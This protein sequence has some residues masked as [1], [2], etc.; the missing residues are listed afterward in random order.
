VSSTYGGCDKWGWNPDFLGEVNDIGDPVKLLA[1]RPTLRLD[2]RLV[3]YWNAP[4]FAGRIRA[5]EDLPDLRGE[6]R[7][8]VDEE[9]PVWLRDAVKSLARSRRLTLIPNPNQVSKWSAITGVAQFDQDTFRASY[10]TEIHLDEHLKGCET[11]AS[12]FARHLPLRLRQ[13]VIEAARL[14]DIGKADP[15][16][17]A[18]LR[19]GNPRRPEELLAKSGGSGQNGVAIERARK[20]AGYP[21][22]GR[23]ELMSVALLQCRRHEFTEIDFELFLHLIGSHHGRCRPFAPVVEDEDTPVAYRGWSASS[24]H[25]LER[26][27][28]GVSERFW[29]LTSRYGWY[30]LA[31][32][33]TLLRTADQCQSEAEQSMEADHEDT[34]YA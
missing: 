28:S 24:N 27:G 1:G 17:Q 33:E 14:H 9:S 4:D 15:R 25:Q 20:L 21:K 7:T 32:L 26:A 34:A 11:W 29:R 3:R 12:Q 16:F 31:Y 30:G 13:T 22:G 10:T 18:W 5:V 2:S 23:H 8:G 6:L 19:C